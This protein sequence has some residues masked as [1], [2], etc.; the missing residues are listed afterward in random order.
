MQISL[1][2]DFAIGIQLPQYD[3]LYEYAHLAGTYCRCYACSP[4]PELCYSSYTG[5]NTGNGL[6]CDGTGYRSD[7]ACRRRVWKLHSHVLSHVLVAIQ[8]S[9]LA[10]LSC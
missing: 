8:V 1:S 5:Q 9:W 6:A 3:P 4:P 7:Q 2:L 10:T